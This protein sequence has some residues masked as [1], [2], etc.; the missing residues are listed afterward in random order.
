MKTVTELAGA[1]RTKPYLF[2]LL[3]SIVLLAA[4]LVA[5]PSFGDPD[6]YPEELAALAPFVLA[7]MASTPSILSGRGG[8]DIS[9]GPLLTLCSIVF[10][11]WLVPHGLGNGFV[12]IPILLVLGAG[13][14]ALN[15]ALV[16]VFRYQPVIAT[17]CTFFVLIGIC[18][19]IASSPQRAAGN[20]TESLSGSIHHV[21]GA[22]I[23]IAAGGLIWLLLGRTPYVRALYA[24]GGNDAAAF[25]AG[26]N[27]TATRIIAYALG[28]ALAALAG[29][30]LTALVQLADSGVTLQYTLVALAA[31]ALGGTPVGGGRGGMLGSVLGAACIYLLQTFLSAVQVPI[32]WLQ[33]VYGGLLIVGVV[34]GAR[35]T[36]IGGTKVAS[37]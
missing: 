34:V 13:V 29:L 25:S 2:A 19:K 5:Q 16:A 12:A 9:I 26:I 8:I 35:M 30:A 7:A 6:N 37:G 3:L 21:P 17:L 15:G 36:S 24:V 1:I 14:G 4:N 32:T 10:V 20:W 31:V 33:V 18:E 23:L 27:V 11:V 28:G 22:L